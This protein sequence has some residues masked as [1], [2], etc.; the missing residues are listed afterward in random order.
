MADMHQIESFYLHFPYCL[1][2]CNY[3]DF[4]SQLS[5]K[6]SISSYHQLL[7]HQLGW[8][9]AFHRQ[10]QAVVMPL[11]SLYIGGGT[12]SL[13]GADGRKWMQQF[14]QTYPLAKDGEWTIEVN[15]GTVTPNELEA[16][17]KIG[18]NRFSIGSQSLDPFYLNALDRIHT[19]KQTM[20]LLKLLKSWQ[21]NFSVDLMLGLPF[22]QPKNRNLKAELSPLLDLDI[23]HL[24]AYIL[25][26]DDDYIH[27]AELPDEEWVSRE[28]LQLAELMCEAGYCH[29]EVSN[30]AK[31]GRESFHNLQ[32]WQN[33]SVA[34]IGAS[35][36]GTIVGSDATH[37]YRF[38]PEQHLPQLEEVKGEERVIEEFFLGLRSSVGVP[39]HY[40][41][42]PQ[43][44]ELLNSWRDQGLAHCDASRVFLTSSGYLVAD[45]LIEQL[46]A[47]KII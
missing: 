41:S 29:Y 30:F 12:P 42:K 24:S 11:R 22:S 21:F 4:Y 13:W 3:C 7:D 26:V 8:L 25:T 2:R 34:A 6:Q 38:D 45:S 1:K 28:Y 43:A 20:D 23:P 27:H 44:T 10:H 36:V 19:A 5:E 17:I 9:A 46:F 40:F 16:W 47:R 32:Y 37:R 39:L 14:L 35:A 33:R 15:P 18:V 31:A